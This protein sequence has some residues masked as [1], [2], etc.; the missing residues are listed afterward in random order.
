[1]RNVIRFT[2]I[3][4]S[5]LVTVGATEAQWPLGRDAQQGIKLGEPGA[6]ITVTGRFQIFVSPNVKSHTFML[7]T[8]T[9]KVW[10]MKKDSTTGDFS[11]QRIPVEQ[12]DSQ[13]TGS[14]VQDKSKPGEK[15]SPKQK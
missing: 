11:L 3:V 14:G 1:M 10:I 7:D 5:C 2:T 13:Q 15:E 12:I 8:D 9:G 4:I 6:T